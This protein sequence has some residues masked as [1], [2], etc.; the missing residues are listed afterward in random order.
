MVDSV[1]DVLELPGDAVRP[2]PEIN[3]RTIRLGEDPVIG[4]L[5]MLSNLPVCSENPQCAALVSQLLAGAQKS[6]SDL[7][8]ARTLDA[9]C[10]APPRDGCDRRLRRRD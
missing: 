10:D 2:A 1:S 3:P 6:K 8:D 4:G 5:Q 9:A 7:T